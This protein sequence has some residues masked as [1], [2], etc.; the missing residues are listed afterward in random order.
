MGSMAACNTQDEE[1]TPKRYE[2]TYEPLGFFS[3]EGHANERN[4]RNDGPLTEWMDHSFGAEGQA[5]QEHKRKYLSQ[6]DE[7]GNPKNPSKP[8]AN[9]DKSFFERDIRFPR[10]DANYHGHLDD[11]SQ[12]PRSSYYNAYEGEL[13]EQIADVTASVPNVEDVRAVAYGTD[14]LIAVDLADES[15]QS[16]TL[17]TIRQ[18]VTPY[19]HGRTVTVVTDE[20]TFSRVRNIDNDLRDGGPRE[21]INFDLQDLLDWVKRNE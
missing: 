16:T 21:A 12:R 13:S 19:L 4:E 17:A 8:L 15:K 6:K 1:A 10:G 11:Q 7:Y 2:D 9:Y 5:I 14:I 3:N 20:G 18:K